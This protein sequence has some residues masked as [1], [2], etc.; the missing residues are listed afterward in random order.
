[1]NP[2][3]Y[4]GGSRSW[5]GGNRGPTGPMPRMGG[6]GCMRG[7]GPG[8]WKRAGP[9]MGPRLEFMILEGGVGGGNPGRGRYMLK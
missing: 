4:R 2:N 1:M 5:K 8:G 6:M 3:A 9:H 7:I